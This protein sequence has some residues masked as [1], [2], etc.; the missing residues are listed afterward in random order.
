MG[1]LR[2]ILGLSFLILVIVVVWQV[3]SCEL[4]NAALHDDLRD[5]AAQVGA[6]IGLVPLSSD[7]QLRDAVIHAASKHDIH[8]EPSQIIVERS[9]P[10]DTPTIYLAADYKL[11]VWVPGYSFTLHFNPSTAK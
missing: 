6:R 2:L 4:A 3:A 7:D 9:G 5:I 11:G 8:L 10:A 1:K